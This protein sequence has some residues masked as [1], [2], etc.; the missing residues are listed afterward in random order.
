[1]FT[2]NFARPMLLARANLNEVTLVRACN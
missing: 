2:K 1:M